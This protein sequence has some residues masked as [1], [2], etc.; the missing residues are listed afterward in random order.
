MSG[1]WR[2]EKWEYLSLNIH[3]DLDKFGGMGWEM[4][5]VIGQTAWFKRPI[6]E[7]NI[8]HYEMT[9]EERDNLLAMAMWNR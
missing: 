4:V 7:E 3:N 1:E 5:A 8:R 9:A 2:G 6:I